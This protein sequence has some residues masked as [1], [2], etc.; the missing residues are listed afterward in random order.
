MPC[1][2]QALDNERVQA[3]WAINRLFKGLWLRQS[4]FDSKSPGHLAPTA[5]RL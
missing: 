1:R 2:N 4:R 3:G 5:E